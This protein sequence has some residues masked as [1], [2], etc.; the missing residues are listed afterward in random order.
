MA[1][2]I[3]SAMEF[4]RGFIRG[5]LEK[6][7]PSV[8]FN[9]SPEYARVLISEL[10]RH[11]ER[12]VLIY[13]RRFGEDVW[14]DEEVLSALLGAIGRGVCIEAVLQERPE[15]NNRALSIL[16]TY[17]KRV[18]IVD[19]VSVEENFLIIDDA[20]YRVE[21]DINARKG[22]ASKHDVK[23]LCEVFESIRKN[24]HPIDRK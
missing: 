2:Q 21:T 8:V 17:G 13:C 7:K 24:S 23:V 22:Y 1:E 15:K 16:T 11:A 3:A 6:G 4:Y 9:D 12:K 14:G 10:L 5:M 20:A 18:F 19:T